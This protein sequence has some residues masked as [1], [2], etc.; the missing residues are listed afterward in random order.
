MGLIKFINIYE[1]DNCKHQGEWSSEWR[2]KTEMSIKTM[3][4]ITYVV[5]SE[6][7]ANELEK[8]WKK[9]REIK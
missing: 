9:Q 8:S 6:K 4:D 2:C 1:C 3:C 5:C 7:C